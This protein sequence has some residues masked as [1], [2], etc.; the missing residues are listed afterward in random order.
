MRIV[1][2]YMMSSRF[3]GRNMALSYELSRKTS[4]HVPSAL[5]VLKGTLSEVLAFPAW[6][7]G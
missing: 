7:V 2:P 5:V 3:A 6:G 4:R 1:W